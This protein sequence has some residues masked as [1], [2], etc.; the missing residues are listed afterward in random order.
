MSGNPAG[1]TAGVRERYSHMEGNW[2]YCCIV[3]LIVDLALTAWAVALKA[4]I[5]SMEARR[6]QGPGPVPLRMEHCEPGKPMLRLV[7]G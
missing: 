1:T 5:Q 2:F 6:G 7:K 4:T 3:L